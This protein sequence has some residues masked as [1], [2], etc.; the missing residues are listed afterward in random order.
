M[1]NYTWL[2]AY[3]SQIQRSQKS[4]WL[5]SSLIPILFLSVLLL[6][7]TV[8]TSI[9]VTFLWGSPQSMGPPLVLRLLCDW[10]FS[11]PSRA[12][13]GLRNHDLLHGWLIG[14]WHCNAWWGH[15]RSLSRRIGFRGDPR[16]PGPP[17]RVALGAPCWQ[18]V[19]SRSLK[20][21]SSKMNETQESGRC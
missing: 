4:L 15:T 2:H 21:Q 11:P 3:L 20:T 18:P 1:F 19:E 14:Q 9:V 17:H 10:A 8:E 13:S 5:F 12:Q 7:A 6:Y 16:G